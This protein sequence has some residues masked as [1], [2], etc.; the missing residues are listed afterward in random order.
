MP[1]TLYVVNTGRPIHSFVAPLLISFL[2]VWCC[3]QLVDIW[4]VFCIVMNF[5]VVLLLVVIEFLKEA[6]RGRKVASV[7]L[8][9]GKDKKGSLSAA[10]ETPFN[11]PLFLNACG[12][13][14]IPVVYFTFVLVYFGYTVTNR[15]VM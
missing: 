10:R 4:F 15:R 9:V 7:M 12:R 1:S 3:R 2:S 6:A 11:V 14:G 13:I 8:V 5:S